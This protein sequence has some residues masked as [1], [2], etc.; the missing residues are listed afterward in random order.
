MTV[1]IHQSESDLASAVSDIVEQ[2]IRSSPDAKLGLATGST[3][4]PI[5]RELVSRYRMAGQK[6]DGLSFAN[7]SA[8][9]LDEYIGLDPSSPETYRNV[10]RSGFIQHIDLPDSSV[11]SPEGD[12]IDPTE[13]AAAYDAA[14]TQAHIDLQLLGIGRNG[15]IAF[16][17]PGSSLASRTRMVNL[18]NTTRADNAR[19]FASPDD[20]PRQA[21]T[22]GI[23]TIL[24]AQQIILIAIGQHKADAVAQAIEGPVTSSLPA[25][26]LQTHPR[27][28]YVLDTAAASKLTLSGVD[29]EVC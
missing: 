1:H 3:I 19:F 18:A 20:V 7:V 8:Y 6:P 17:E 23:A 12:S 27:V 21:I 11:H 13:Q 22:Q 10:I 28:T 9:L 25:S 24:S 2:T 5:Y 26:A 16:N 15:H 4:E 29:R 14:V